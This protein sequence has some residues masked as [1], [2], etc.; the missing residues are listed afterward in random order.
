MKHLIGGSLIILSLAS[1]GFAAGEGNAEANAIL[2]KVVQ[3]YDHLKSYQVQTLSITEIRSEFLNQQ[4]RRSSLD[5]A[6]KPD[7]L[8]SES[9][10]PG[11]GELR[12]SDGRMMWVHSFRFNE[13]QKKGLA[14][15]V[16][17]DSEGRELPPGSASP[18][19]G[20]I[21]RQLH[22]AEKVKFARIVGKEAID[23]EGGKF[24][25]QVLEVIYETSA[26]PGAPEQSWKYWI[27]ADRFLV[28][29]DVFRAQFKN[30]GTGDPMEQ[31]QT[32]TYHWVSLNQPLPD[33]LFVYNPPIGAREVIEFGK[34]MPADAAGQ[35]AE[36]FALPDLEGK[37]VSLKSLRGKVVLLDFWATWCGPCRIELPT[38]EALH[39]EYK[40][41]GLVVLG[42]DDESPEKPKAYIKS[43]N[44]TFPTLI[45]AQREV[46]AKYQIRAI[47]TVFIIDKEGRISSR[48]LGVSDHDLLV[49]AIRKAGL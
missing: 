45:D 49:E 4:T 28:L 37:V 11:G 47:P 25:C 33:A 20:P 31:I 1:S 42:I 43:N 13:Y 41:K 38:I 48:H 5:A 19:A 32:D 39:R 2:E 40:D 15:V 34:P 6:V 3:A 29:K 18:W 8:R 21:F 26:V 7:K 44:L 35:V 17:A 16:F 24:D 9:K 46:I 36:E 22:L 10:G 30:E 27:D 12:V 23:T 14:D